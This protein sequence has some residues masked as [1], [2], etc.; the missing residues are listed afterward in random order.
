MSSSY[1]PIIFYNN[2]GTI[3]NTTSYKKLKE[4]INEAFPYIVYN[5]EQYEL[6]YYSEKDQKMLKN[7]LMKLK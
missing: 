4:R 6:F 2:V 3:K 5:E 1:I 7:Q